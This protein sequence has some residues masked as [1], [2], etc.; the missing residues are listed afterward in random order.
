MQELLL[1]VGQKLGAGAGADPSA[2][3]DDKAK[4]TAQQ[5]KVDAAIGAAIDAATDRFF[6]PEIR[7]RLA[8]RMKDS[9][10]SILVRAGRERAALVV[11]TAEA[12]VAAG[13]ITSPPHEVPFLRAFFQK[14]LAMV[15]AHPAGDC[16]FQC[17]Q[18][19]APL[20]RELLK[21]DRPDLGQSRSSAPEPSPIGDRT[22]LRVGARASASPHV[23]GKV[24]VP[25]SGVAVILRLAM[26][27]KR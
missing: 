18:G 10:I 1:D 24:T 22:G 3:G 21:E 8:A 2:E 11:A 7:E 23:A 5:E 4:A 27:M 6:A 15:A 13:L 16:R 19:D 14:G 25:P 17:P 9:T 12:A 26:P 20:P